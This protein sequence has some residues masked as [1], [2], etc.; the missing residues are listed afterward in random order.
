MYMCDSPLPEHW[1]LVQNVVQSMLPPPAVSVSAPLNVESV[2][3]FDPR[4]SQYIVHFIGFIGVRDAHA[5]STNQ[6]LV[7][8][9]EEMWRYRARIRFD[10]PVRQASAASARSDV[11]VN[12]NTVE[13]DTAE[14]REAMI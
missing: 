8:L 2:I 13:L 7:P 1:M 4:Q 11:R 10:R 9:M 6:S 12:G 14:I 5:T 3:T